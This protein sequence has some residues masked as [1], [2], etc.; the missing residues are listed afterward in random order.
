LLG[1]SSVQQV[2]ISEMKTFPRNARKMKDGFSKP[3]QG[4]I[5]AG[6]VFVHNQETSIA[7]KCGNWVEFA[8]GVVKAAASR[9]SALKIDKL[10]RYE[11]V[12]MVD[13]SF[14][15][16][17]PYASCLVPHHRHQGL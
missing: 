11:T 3:E 2:D 6:W 17:L 10:S 7:S 9:S 8:D 15:V 12:R 5:A 1:S 16:V 4:V 13:D 14:V